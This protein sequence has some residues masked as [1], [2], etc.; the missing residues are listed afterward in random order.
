MNSSNILIGPGYMSWNGGYFRFMEPGIRAR[1]IKNLM[2]VSADEFGKFDRTQ[3]KRR[4]TISGRLW[5]GWENLPLLFPSA[6]FNPVIGGKLFGTANL[7]AV[8][9]GADGSR[10]TV[11]NTQITKLANLMLSVEKPLFGADVQFTGLL[12]SGGNPGTVGD[13]Y[14]YSTGNSYQAP[15][16]NKANFRAPVL[17]AAWGGTLVNGGTSFAAFN[18]KGGAAIDWEWGLDFEPCDVDG[19]GEVDAII[20]D[21]AGTCKGTPIGV[22]EADAASAMLPAQALGLLES[23]LGGDLS[24]TFGSNSVILKEAIISDHAGFAWS[25]KNNRIGDMTWLS[26]VPFT[27]GVPGERASVS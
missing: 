15:A 11:V 4:I 1:F 9:N 18:F 6:A 12:L 17:S 7:P 23:L 25:K 5:S 19:Y 14:T 22:I 24:L 16:F 27:D 10:L 20:T 21:F 8:I 2:A 3:T 26:T 13:Y